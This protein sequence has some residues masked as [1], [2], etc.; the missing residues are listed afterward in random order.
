MFKSGFKS[1]TEDER[2]KVKKTDKSYYNLRFG[3]TKGY[4]FKCDHFKIMILRILKVMSSTGVCDC[5]AETGTKC[6]SVDA[7]R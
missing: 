5:K 2:Q 6:M 4:F 7:V 3:H 1:Q